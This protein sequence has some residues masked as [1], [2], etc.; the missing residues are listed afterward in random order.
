MIGQ[1]SQLTLR[2]NVSIFYINDY[3]NDFTS[4][5]RARNHADT[6]KNTT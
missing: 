2:E 4:D 5:F 6:H 3:A 1:F